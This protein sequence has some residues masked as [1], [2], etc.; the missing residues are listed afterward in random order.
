MYCPCLE[1]S[2]REPIRFVCYVH[3]NSISS[4]PGT[5]PTLIYVLLTAVTDTPDVPLN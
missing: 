5:A 1:H 4:V 2:A 3:K